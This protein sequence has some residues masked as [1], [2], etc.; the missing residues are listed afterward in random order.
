MNLRPW[1]AR[2]LTVLLGS[3]A[4]SVVAALLSGLLHAGGDRAGAAAV[5][6]VLWVAAA[7]AVLTLVGQVVLL[8]LIE[9][10]RRESAPS[11]APPREPASTP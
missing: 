8:S 10:Q 2:G 3:L 4:L 5:Q 6:G 1:I 11:D 7:V 9:L